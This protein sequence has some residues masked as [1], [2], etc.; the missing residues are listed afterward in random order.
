MYQSNTQS[1]TM[2]IPA[3]LLDLLKYA[4]IFLLPL[5]QTLQN[6]QI[7]FFSKKKSIITKASF[8]SKHFTTL[9]NISTN[10]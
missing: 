10:N 6:T 5:R 2:H 9:K 3:I 7:F 4:I 8:L 1:Q